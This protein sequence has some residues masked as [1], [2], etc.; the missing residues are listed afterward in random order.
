MLGV[1]VLAGIKD[2]GTRGGKGLAVARE[3]LAMEC[4]RHVNTTYLP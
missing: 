1:A 2:G 4:N 3:H